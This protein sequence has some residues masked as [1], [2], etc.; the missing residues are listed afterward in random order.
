MAI[1]HPE[2]GVLVDP[3]FG[4]PRPA[5][6]FEGV[7]TCFDEFLVG[8]FAGVVAEGVGKHPIGGF[9]QRLVAVHSFGTDL[10]RRVGQGVDMTRT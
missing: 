3:Q 8:P 9:Q 2:A 10:V 7:D 6:P 4:F 1:T 5:L